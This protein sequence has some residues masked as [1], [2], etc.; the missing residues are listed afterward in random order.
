MGRQWEFDKR[1]TGLC[2]V[3]RTLTRR[4]RLSG[5]AEGDFRRALVQTPLPAPEP[6]AIRGGV[7]PPTLLAA[8]FRIGKLRVAGS[9]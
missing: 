2:A 6:G 5:K 8:G 4:G 1:N 7:V 3:R 9:R